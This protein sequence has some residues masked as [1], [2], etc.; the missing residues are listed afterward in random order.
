MSVTKPTSAEA[1]TRV[2]VLGA[3]RAGGALPGHWAPG[4]ATLAVEDDWSGRWSPTSSARSSTRSA[5]EPKA[6]S[7]LVIRS[8]LKATPPIASASSHKARSRSAAVPEGDEVK[9]AKLGGGIIGEVGILAET[10]R[11]ATV[12]GDDVKL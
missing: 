8:S 1:S 7:P 6:H 2:R 3:F 5:S 11:T 12:G 10:R 4:D 9:L